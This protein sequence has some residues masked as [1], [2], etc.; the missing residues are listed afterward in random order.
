VKP[1]HGYWMATPNDIL[2]GCGC[3]LCNSSKGELEV[4]SILIEKNIFFIKNKTFTG[5]KHKSLLK[6]DFY[7]PKY[8]ICIEYD[9][10]QHFKPISFFGGNEQLKENKK[11]DKI[12]N[13]FCKNNGIFLIRIPYTEFNEIRY[14]LS[15]LLNL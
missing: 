6:F 11:R 14:I 4:E 9:G 5:C 2:D 10:L 13:K 15:S 7:L 1:E 8:N 12:K 3:P